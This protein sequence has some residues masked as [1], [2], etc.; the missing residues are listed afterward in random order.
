MNGGR[1]ECGVLEFGGRALSEGVCVGFRSSVLEGISEGV[2]K[3]RGR[4]LGVG[5]VAGLGFCTAGGRL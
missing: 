4:A 3:C 2:S 5:V 1:L